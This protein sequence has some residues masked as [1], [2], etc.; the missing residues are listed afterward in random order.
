[1]YKVMIVDD[2]VPILKYMRALID[3]NKLELQ[4]VESLHSSV[5][6]LERFSELLPDILITDIDM[7]QYNGMELVERCR[8][9]KPDLRVIFLTCHEEFEYA[10]G[11]IQL[12]ADDYLIKDELTADK[13]EASLKKTAKWLD[14]IYVNYS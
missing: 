1:M 13:L 9:V 2:Y 14:D 8:E 4:V 12:Q 11:A 3:W 6:A 7:P 10:K 5:K